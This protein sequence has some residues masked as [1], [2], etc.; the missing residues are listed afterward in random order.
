MKIR[1]EDSK[2]IY[3]QFQEKHMYGIVDRT[4]DF[5]LCHLFYDK[6]DNWVGLEVFN[7]DDEG[8][9]FDLPPIDSIDFPTYQAEITQSEKKIKILF[10]RNVEVSKIWEPE[11]NIDIHSGSI[12]GIE[13]LIFLKESIGGRNVAQPFIFRDC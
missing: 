10:N 7:E 4:L 5:M 13:I 9:V 6:D 1:I 2:M 8:N 3:I 12:Y 11:C